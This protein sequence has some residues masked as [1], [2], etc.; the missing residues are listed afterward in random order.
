MSTP[1]EQEVMSKPLTIAFIENALSCRGTS[2][3]LYNMAFYNEKILGNKSVIITRPLSLTSQLK[4]EFNREAYELFSTRW[5]MYYY[6]NTSEI[7]GLI[8]KN[9]IDLVFIEKAGSPEDGLIVNSVPSIIHAVFETRQPHGSLYCAISHALNEHHRT[10][11]PVI[12]YMVNVMDHRENMR[13]KLGIPKEAIVFGTYSGRECFNIPYV[14]QAVRDIASQSDKYPN[15]YFIFM[16]I[17]PFCDASGGRVIFLEGTTDLYMKRKF[18]NTCNA[19]L[20]GRDQGETFGLAVG[21]FSVCNKPAICRLGEPG[22]SHLKILKGDVIPH[23]SYGE[24]FDILTHFSEYNKD[25]R[26][27]GYTKYTPEKIM[28]IFNYHVN[29]LMRDSRPK[30][31]K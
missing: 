5:P 29:K 31:E 2:V 16:N 6:T 8:V 22:D 15:I 3:T 10:N 25:V 28:T 27:N 14:Q 4:R 20:Y 24:L 23:T 11:I 26:G 1:T 17:E 30:T 7:D 12:P 9:G 18:I 13:E 21:E 19:Q